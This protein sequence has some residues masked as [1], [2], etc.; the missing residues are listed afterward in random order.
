MQMCRYASTVVL[1]LDW[2]VSKSPI[3][4]L[5]CVDFLC[6]A[7]FFCKTNRL[8][9]F[10]SAIVQAEWAIQI[11]K[12][13]FEAWIQERLCQSFHRYFS[14]LWQ[15]SYYSKSDGLL[16]TVRSVWWISGSDVTALLVNPMEKPIFRNEISP[17]DT[18]G[19]KALATKQGIG[20]GFGNSKI[21][22]DM[23]HAERSRQLITGIEN[24]TGHRKNLLM[25]KYRIRLISLND[26]ESHSFS[27]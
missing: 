20:C 11:F 5:C 6:A 12:C 1:W 4:A 24:G 23:S 7:A 27:K 14:L 16:V 18:Q 8:L 25:V 21:S 3:S 22:S 10:F 2:L 19:G 13:V 17:I 9:I 15:R 26:Y